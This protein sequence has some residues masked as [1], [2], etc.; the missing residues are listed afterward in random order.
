MLFTPFDLGPLTLR[1]RLVMAPMTRC[2]ADADHRPT[3]IMAAY[4]AQRASMGLIV[5]EGTAPSPNGAGYAR[6]PGLYDPA[7]GDGWRRVTDAV[8]AEGGRIFLQLMHTGRASVQLNLPAGA[9]VVGVTP[10]PLS[11]PLWT[12]AAGMQ[13]PTPP[14]PLRAD[15]IPR[16]VAEYAAA[17]RLARDAGFD[18]VELHGGSGYLP[19]QFLNAHINTRTDGYGGSAQGRN[20][21]TLEVLEALARAIG[22]DRVG[23]RLTPFSTFNETGGFDGLEAQFLD[24]AE[25]AGAL[26]LVYLHV[27]TAVSAGV[28]PVLRP[29]L[30]GLRQRF[31]RTFILCGGFDRARAEL[32]L[33]RG[34]ADLIG[35]GR[36][37]LANPDL[38]ERLHAGAPLNPPDPATFYA[39]GP[40]G[41]TDYPTLLASPTP[42]P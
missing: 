5:A 36:P 27:S 1:N 33:E 29:F 3:P 11:T 12:D 20:R 15:E 42:N 19:D 14:R 21:F 32:A 2:R 18:G 28:P 16:V 22:P 34:E 6:I 10:Q 31:G 35:F 7:Q 41:Y 8:H 40:A 4:Y 13:P 23:L 39:K 26:D 30:E 9:E 24:L 38:V 25:H 17:A 37:A